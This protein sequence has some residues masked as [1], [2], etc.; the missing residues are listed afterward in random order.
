MIKIVAS[1]IIFL[2]LVLCLTGCTLLF[3]NQLWR[4]WRTIN[5][6][7]RY[8]LDNRVSLELPTFRDEYIGKKDDYSGWLYTKW[9]GPGMGDIPAS[10]ISTFN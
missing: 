5:F 7:R 1:G 2:I 8:Y 6:E 10:E 4:N 9:K 3:S